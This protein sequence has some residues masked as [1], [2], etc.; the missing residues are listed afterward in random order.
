MS[1]VTELLS[2]IDS[3]LEKRNIDS[4]SCVQRII[5]SYVNEAERNMQKGDANTIDQVI[6]S[7]TQ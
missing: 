4:S 7:V 1:S 5:C 2:N 3:S 6:Y